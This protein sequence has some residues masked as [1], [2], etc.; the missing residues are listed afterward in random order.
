MISFFVETLM[1][2]LHVFLAIEGNERYLQA[3]RHDKKQT[4]LIK[5][6]AYLKILIPYK[7]QRVF[8]FGDYAR[9]FS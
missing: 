6:Y 9:L 1:Q 2:I 4:D 3:K 8:Y 7:I 5:F